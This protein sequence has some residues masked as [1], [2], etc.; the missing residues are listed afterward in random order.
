MKILILL[1]GEKPGISFLQSQKYDKLFCADGAGNYLFANGVT[2]DV[3]MGDMDSIDKQVLEYYEENNVSIL[4]AKREK[5]ETDGQLLVDRALEAMPEEIIIMGGLGG[6][7]DHTLGNLQ[8]LLRCER[9]GVL[10]S[11]LSEQEE[12]RISTGKVV[13]LG[14]GGDLVS[15]IPMMPDTVLTTKG[16]KYEVRGL[17]LPQDT[18]IGVS[19][20]MTREMSE[21]IIESG[22]A[23]ILHN[24]NSF[25]RKL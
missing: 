4:R 5:D 7:L 14:D 18:P 9:Q 13:L 23:A 17:L 11:C 12:V 21:V 1:D 24:K 22:A 25:A 20:E 6:R 15:V 10:A 19:N 8:L 16:M 3:L 2:P